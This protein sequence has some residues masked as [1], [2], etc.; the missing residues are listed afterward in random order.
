MILPFN[1]CTSASHAYKLRVMQVVNKGLKYMLKGET[2][3]LYEYRDELSKFG[4]YF[5]ERN[6]VAGATFIYTVYK[7]TEHILPEQMVNLEGIYLTAFEKMFALL[8]DSGW[9]L[10]KEPKEGEELELYEEPS[11]EELSVLRYTA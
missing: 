4:Q 7:M 3:R 9:Q 11:E 6:N 2:N 5:S 1:H 10:Q 8:E